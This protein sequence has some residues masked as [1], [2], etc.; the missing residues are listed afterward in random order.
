RAWREGDGAGAVALMRSN[1]AFASNRKLRGFEWNVLENSLS[2]RQTVIA[3]SSTAEFTAARISPID[4]TIAIAC[5]DGM[6]ILDRSNGDRQLLEGHR[7][8][9]HA[10]DFSPNGRQLISGSADGDIRIWDVANGNSIGVIEKAHQGADVF[11][12]RYFHDGRSFVSGGGD[13]FA[14]IW[15]AESLQRRRSCKGHSREVRSVDVSADDRLIAT[16]SN[17]RE[18]RVW[19]VSTGHCNQTLRNHTGMILAIAFTVDDRYVITGSNDH[20]IRLWDHRSGQEVAVLKGHQDAVQSIAVTSDGERF[21]AGDRGGNLKLWQIEG[22]RA[23][24]Q[25]RERSLNDCLSVRF[26]PDGRSW[27]ALT[28][29][30]RLVLRDLASKRTETLLAALP[31]HYPHQQTEKLVFA[32]HGDR[33]FCTDRIISP[34]HGTDS[35]PTVKLDVLAGAAGQFSPDGKTLAA[36]WNQEIRLFDSQTGTAVDQIESPVDPLLGARFSTD[37]SEL[38][39][40]SLYG[41]IARCDLRDKTFTQGYAHPRERIVDLEWDQPGGRIVACSESG[42]VRQWQESTR[43]W[44]P[45]ELGERKPSSICWGPDRQ[46]VVMTSPG[47]ESVLY[48]FDEPSSPE[49]LAVN[50]DSNINDYASQT[51]LLLTAGTTSGIEV[52]DMTQLEIRSSRDD[53]FQGHSDRVWAVD[54]SADDRRFLSVSR[55]RTARMWRPSEDRYSW[56]SRSRHPVDQVDDLQW[57]IDGNVLA[58][59]QFNRVTLHDWKTGEQTFKSDQI[60]PPADV[61]LG[62]IVESVGIDTDGKFVAAGY[63]DGLVRVWER[64]TEQPTRQLNAKFESHWISALTFSSNRKWLAGCNRQ[65]NVIVIWETENWSLVHRLDAAD[66]DDIHFSP[67]DGNQLLFCDGLDAVI[68]DVATGNELQRFGRHSITVHGVAFS[69]DGRLAATACEDRKLRVWDVKNGSVLSTLGG[70]SAPILQVAFSSDDKTIATGDESGS[71]RLWHLPTG[72][73]L[74]ELANL[75]VQVRRLRFVPGRNVLVA[76]GEDGRANV[77]DGEPLESK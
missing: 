64:S 27:A 15:D 61:P 3:E 77:F 47:L 44:T 22:R 29:D 31:N 16:A 40:W 48:R 68:F 28:A 50:R 55:D 11:A 25:F 35:P 33:L 4:D 38:L 75:G 30:G 10:L 39:V 66:C 60:T 74:Y 51:S 5:S 72:H 65:E 58:L 32:P 43:M 63:R 45:L 52:R 67:V 7:S 69:N 71:I 23:V 73:E 26:A 62:Y 34:Q 57:S 12:C 42:V 17:D 53:S 14:T 54:V 49:R 36:V 56:L 19:N 76:V 1:P 2:S 6:V 13:H 21:I 70:H 41:E 46:S 37:G 9:V 24:D 18:A 20:T 59:A 8:Q